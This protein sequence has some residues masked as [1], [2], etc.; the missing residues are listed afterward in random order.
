[1]KLVGYVGSQPIHMLVDS[2][3][4]HN[5]LDIATMKKLRCEVLKIPPIVVV[6]ANGAKLTC[7][8]M[9]KEFGFTLGNAKYVTD[10]YIVF[11]GSC[12]MI[13]GVQWL[14]TLGSILWNFEELTMEFM[15]GGKKQ[16]LQGCTKPELSWSTGKRRR[17]VHQRAQV[18]SIQVVPLLC[19]GNT[20]L[21]HK[22]DIS[23]KTSPL[24]QFWQN[25]LMSLL[26]QELF[27]LTGVMIIRSYSRR[28]LLL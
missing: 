24:A 10:A 6:V 18:F 17:V 22:E 25:T 23:G 12:D 3:S 1:M 15:W 28:E 8:A 26:S 27:P 9:C 4:T 7:Q 13:L 20:T 2:G 14:S 21:Q 16:V 11:L 5:F 19:Q